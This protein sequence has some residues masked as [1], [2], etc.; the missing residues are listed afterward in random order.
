MKK[1]QD[2]I[3]F[4]IVVALIRIVLGLGLVYADAIIV[5]VVALVF[6]DAVVEGVL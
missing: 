1:T 6:V 3:Y 4:F 5:I 2:A